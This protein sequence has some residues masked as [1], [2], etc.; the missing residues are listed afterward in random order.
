[1][2][3]PELNSQKTGVFAGLIIPLVSFI[4]FYLFRYGHIP[5]LEFLRYVWF[6]DILAP[7][8]SLNMLPNLLIFYLFIRKNYLLSARGVLVATFIFAGIILLFKVTSWL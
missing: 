6:R 7:L 2:R 1:M 3:K 4:L 8:L 5:F